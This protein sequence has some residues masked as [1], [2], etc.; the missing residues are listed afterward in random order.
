MNKSDLAEAR[1]AAEGFIVR[2]AYEYA[3]A[4]LGYART[5]GVGYC[6]LTSEEKERALDS[7]RKRLLDTAERLGVAALVDAT[8]IPLPA[9]D[10]I[11][12]AGQAVIDAED[13][14]PT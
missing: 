13:E 1:R 9:F 10:K 6:K 3:M 7:A 5:G 8:L 4:C 11:F 2:D 12:N 14:T